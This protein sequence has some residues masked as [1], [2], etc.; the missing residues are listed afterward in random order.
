MVSDIRHDWPDELKDMAIQ[1]ERLMLRVQCLQ[2]QA[3]A[4]MDLK[5]LDM[6]TDQLISAE[7]KLDALTR[8]YIRAK[9]EYNISTL[10]G[11]MTGGK[12]TE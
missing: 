9:I 3:A 7:F 6:I 10:C 5:E 12:Q 1:H 2:N 11:P 8:E 4:C